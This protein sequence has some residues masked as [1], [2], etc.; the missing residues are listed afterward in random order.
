MVRM[1]KTNG[2]VRCLPGSIQIDKPLLFNGF[3]RQKSRS[4]ALLGGSPAPSPAP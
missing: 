4:P 3:W 1:G 2:D